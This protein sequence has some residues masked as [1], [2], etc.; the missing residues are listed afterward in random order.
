MDTIN[1]KSQKSFNDDLYETSLKG[2]YFKYENNKYI[3][4]THHNLTIDR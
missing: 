4:S 1:L 2:F 3:F